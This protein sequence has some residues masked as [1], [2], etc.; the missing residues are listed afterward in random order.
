MGFPIW[1]R[2]HVYIDSVPRFFFLDILR[3]E[4]HGCCFADNIFKFIFLYENCWIWFKIL[5]T[6]H[7]KWALVQIMAWH[8]TGDKPLSEPTMFNLLIHICVT[9]PQWVKPS[10]KRWFMNGMFS[11]NM[12][13]FIQSAEV[14]EFWP[15]LEYCHF[16]VWEDKICPLFI[17]YSDIHFKIVIN[18]FFF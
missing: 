6:K 14:A 10:P 18:F 5:L 7:N 16:R 8:L 13:T 9:W 1:V 17:Y 15:L 11:R 3:P 12:S 2:W 4:Q